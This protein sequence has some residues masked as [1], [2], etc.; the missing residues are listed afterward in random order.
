MNEQIAGSTHKAI[1]AWRV[2]IQ[3]TFND[4]RWNV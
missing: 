4:R 1:N 2:E 3:K